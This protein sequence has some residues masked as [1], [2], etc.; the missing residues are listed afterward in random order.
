MIVGDSNYMVE[1]E[2]PIFGGLNLDE[3]K[4]YKITTL[5]NRR[6]VELQMFLDTE[7]ST[8]S[9]IALANYM[10]GN[11]DEIDGKAREFII[12]DYDND[13]SPTKKYVERNTTAAT[14]SVLVGLR[15]VFVSIWFYFLEAK[16]NSF[17]VGYIL[18]HE[19]DIVRVEFDG[20]GQ[21]MYTTI[22]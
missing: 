15:L 10:F 2:L 12:K 7:R 11:I 6:P 17:S 16:E 8:E 20:H 22:T 18:G 5:V 14:K 13:G 3:Q 1:V 4:S 9:N 19:D 21:P